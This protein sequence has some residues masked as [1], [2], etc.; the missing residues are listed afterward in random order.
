M[1][2][3]MESIYSASAL[4]HATGNRQGQEAVVCANAWSRNLS[5]FGNFVVCRMDAC[6]RLV[7]VL[8]V[9]VLGDDRMCDCWGRVLWAN[10][11]G[12]APAGACLGTL[13]CEGSPR[14]TVHGWGSGKLG[15][16]GAGEFDNFSVQGRGPSPSGFNGE[17]PLLTLERFATRLEELRFA[18]HPGRHN[19]SAYKNDAPLGVC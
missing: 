15:V 13:G 11:L 5:N 7:C 16:Q 10:A 2:C 3:I 18:K 4:T 1:S 9:T 6:V 17:L 12:N 8:W 19:C 14:R